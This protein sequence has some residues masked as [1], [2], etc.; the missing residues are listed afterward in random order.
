MALFLLEEQKAHHPRLGLRIFECR[1]TKEGRLVRLTGCD[2][3]KTEILLNF[4][5]NP[6]YSMAFP[7]F[8]V[9]AAASPTE[10]PAN[11]SSPPRPLGGCGIRGL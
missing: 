8:D 4:R 10:W 9:V 11:I 5:K 1:A 6:L 3:L 2:R 7:S